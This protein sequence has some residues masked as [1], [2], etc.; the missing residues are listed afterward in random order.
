VCTERSPRDC[1][2]YS[3]F[4]LAFFT[5]F[6]IMTFDSLNAVMLDGMRL[7]GTSALLFFLA[8][9]MLGSLTLMVRDCDPTEHLQ[10]GLAWLPNLSP[11][12]CAHTEP[13]PR[14][15]AAVIR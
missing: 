12:S 10:T 14:Y 5:T 4:T 3:S 7:F 15:C 9:I 1:V 6:Q 13:A 11:R 2:Y 8:W